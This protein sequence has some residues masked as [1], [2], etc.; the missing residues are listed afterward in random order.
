M[1]SFKH[2][3]VASFLLMAAT[4]PAAAAQ[5]ATGE[6]Q[7]PAPKT[8]VQALPDKAGETAPASVTV[9]NT[10]AAQV[11]AAASAPKAAVPWRGSSLTYGHATTTVSLDK[12]ALLDYN[13]T[14]AHRLELAPQWNFNE[15]LYVRAR[16]ELGQELTQ[17]DT[18]EYAHEVAFSDIT[19]DV[20]TSG[21]Q[22]PR[23]GI[24][25]SG[26]LRLTAPT[27]K[28]SWAQT[29]VFSVG[30][31]LALSRSFPVRNGLSVRYEARYTRRFHRF[32]TVQFEAPRL[33]AC[34]DVESLECAESSHTGVR[35]VMQ[36]VVHGASLSFQPIEKLS[37]S[38]AFMW[39]HGFLYGLTP[40]DLP[41]RPNE[42]ADPTA[43]RHASIFSFGASYQILD[44][45]NLGAGVT[46][47]TPPSL[48][49]TEKPYSPF[50]NQFTTLYLDLGIDFEALLSRS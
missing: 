15:L 45:L 1:I 50:F 22:D 24:R 40:T 28:T 46:T 32:T 9:T 39:S 18:Y 10:P 23:T 49:P 5:G 17:S 38:G 8:A 33:L 13:P 21:W 31:R 43:G 30:P 27:S 3:R 16:L 26:D 6:A 12:G 7:A 42:N 37:V 2:V 25:I 35:N 29:K 48:N 4:F 19:A 44:A 36:D 11:K 34:S 14:Y 41:V 20:G 47:I